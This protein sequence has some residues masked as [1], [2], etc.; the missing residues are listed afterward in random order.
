[1]NAQSL[2]VILHFH[3]MTLDTLAFMDMNIVHSGIIPISTV[4]DFENSSAKV[5]WQSES[6]CHLLVAISSSESPL[7]SGNVSHTKKKT[8]Q[9]KAIVM[10]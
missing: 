5:T 3:L 9:L 1:M 10:Q 4:E 8:R 2:S 6:R 7:V